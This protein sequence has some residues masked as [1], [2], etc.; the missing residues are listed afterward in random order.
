MKKEKLSLSALR[1][2]AVRKSSRKNYSLNKRM[3][4]Q[5]SPLGFV[6]NMTKTESRNLEVKDLNSRGRGN[7]K[8]NDQANIMTTSVT[9]SNPS[10]PRL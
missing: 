5:A 7:S 10:S 2:S 8:A 6:E 4:F 3:F 1:A 9:N